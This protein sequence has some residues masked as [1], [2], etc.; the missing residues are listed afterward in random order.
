MSSSKSFV[1]KSVLSFVLEA[2]FGQGNS[3]ILLPKGSIYFCI[4]SFIK[5]VAYEIVLCP[6]KLPVTENSCFLRVSKGL[7]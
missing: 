7:L 3:V 4:I 5:S 2:S 6:G 1:L